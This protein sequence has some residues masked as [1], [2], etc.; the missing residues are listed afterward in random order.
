VTALIDVRNLTVKYGKQ[1]VLNNINLTINEGDVLGIIGRSGAGKTILLHVI[2]GLDE[3][4]PAQGSVRLMLLS[5]VCFPYFTV[6]FLTSIR[7]V[8]AG[9]SG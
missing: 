9:S 7:A 1:T 6:R 4:I 2:R 8:T 3:D 5:T